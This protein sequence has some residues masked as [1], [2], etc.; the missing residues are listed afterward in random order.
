MMKC[1]SIFKTKKRGKSSPELREQNASTKPP[2]RLVKSTGS[3]SSP[4]TIPEL[5]KEKGHNL[6]KFSFSELRNATN[7]FNRLLKIGEGGFG[8]V[9]KGSLRPP[10]GQGPPLVAAIKKL[11]R[12]GMQGH[13][14]WLAEVQFLGV[15]DHPNLVKL[16]GYCSVDGERGIQRLLVYEYMP[17]KSLEAHLFSRTL[18]PIPWKTRLRILLG[19]AE[20]LAYL[21]EGLEIQVIFRDFKSSNVLLDEKFN[22]KLSDFGL[23]REGPQGDRTHVSTMPVGTYGYAAPEYVET[24]HLKSK[25][26]LWSFGVVLYEILSGRKAIDRN[27]PQS[28]QKLI[29]WVK[30]FPADSKRFRMMMD[31]RLKNE[32]SME[33]ARKVAKLANSC[34]RRNPDERPEMSRIVDVLQE[35]IRESEEDT[36]SGM[37]PKRRMGDVA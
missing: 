36:I 5:Y 22:A 34:L 35:A 21:H 25:S 27:L 9:Y 14:E 37:L 6:T 8:S 19:A 2:T 24:G 4:R 20:G 10:H 7:N 33:G 12:N 15:V 28:E 3:I 23:A 17:N 11:N 1:F 26:D 18:P 29:E 16:L 13:K 31:P 32:Y 30:Q